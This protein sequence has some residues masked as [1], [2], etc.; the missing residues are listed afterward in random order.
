[1]SQK[2]TIN[3]LIR[4][5][6][7]VETLIV[8]FLLVVISCGLIW[9]LAWIWVLRHALIKNRTVRT[10]TLL[11]CGHRLQDQQPTADYV[12]RLSHAAQL[13]GSVPNLR[14]ILLGGGAPS[15]AAA[16]RRW[17]LA[18]TTVPDVAIEL[19]PQSANSFENLRH[20]R[21][22]YTPAEP[23]Y[24]LSSRYH[25]GRLRV[26]A[27]ELGMPVSLLAA[28]PSFLVNARNLWRTIAEASYLC[29]FVCGLSW[30][31]LGRRKAMLRRL[32]YQG[33]SE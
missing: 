4:D 7:L 5:P 15:E 32:E 27:R 18:N 13:V 23:V 24:L 31:R 14:L 2:F 10:G 30:A 6:V 9:L 1:M 8:S 21:E 19:E 12:A 16:G 28:E 20:A 3:N 33:T 25:L 26:L 29:W 17:L 11:V 22:L